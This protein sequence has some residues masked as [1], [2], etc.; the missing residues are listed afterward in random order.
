MRTLM[1]IIFD[2]I[3]YFFGLFARN[4]KVWI[5]HKVKILG[6]PVTRSQQTDDRHLAVKE[7]GMDAMKSPGLKFLRYEN[8]YCLFEAGSGNYS[9]ESVYVK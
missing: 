1:L 7:G 8:N 5:S 6:S 4:R 9:F 3:N 2:V